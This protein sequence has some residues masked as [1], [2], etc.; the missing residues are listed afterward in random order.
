MDLRPIQWVENKQISYPFLTINTW[1]EYIVKYLKWGGNGILK[2]LLQQMGKYFFYKEHGSGYLDKAN[3]A[4][5]LDCK[6][7]ASS[8]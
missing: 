3:W 2:I 5:N 1:V 7:V 6:M 8:N 4:N